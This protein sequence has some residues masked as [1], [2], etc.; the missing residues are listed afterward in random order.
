MQ[1]GVA[2]TRQQKPELSRAQRLL[3]HGVH[4]NGDLHTFQQLAMS[5]ASLHAAAEQPC[6]SGHQAAVEAAQYSPGQP[7][8]KPP[9]NVATQQ[10]CICCSIEPV[11]SSDICDWTICRPASKVLHF[12]MIEPADI[13]IPDPAWYI[14]LPPRSLYA[15]LPH[16]LEKP[17]GRNQDLC[18]FGAFC[19]VF[20][21]FCA[22]FARPI[23]AGSA[24]FGAIRS[25]SETNSFREEWPSKQLGMQCTTLWDPDQCGPRPKAMRSASNLF[26]ADT[27]ESGIW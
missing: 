11:P 25:H 18:L 4:G 15:A 1:G 21:G 26:N 10:A 16:I 7:A 20:V 12:C 22:A 14:F 13:D 2:G 27:H 8:P 17:Q 5:T 6:Q 24:R 23:R 19:A 9:A 3:P